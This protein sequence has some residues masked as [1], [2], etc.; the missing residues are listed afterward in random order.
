MVIPLFTV[1]GLAGLFLGAGAE[2][3][4][5]SAGVGLFFASGL[6]IFLSLKRVFDALDSHR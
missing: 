1:I 2:G 4:L 6:I 5:Q 3:S